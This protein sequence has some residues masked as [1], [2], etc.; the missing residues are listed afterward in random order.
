MKDILALEK[1]EDNQTL[2][3]MAKK[4]AIIKDMI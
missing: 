3:S 4:D 2:F 1:I